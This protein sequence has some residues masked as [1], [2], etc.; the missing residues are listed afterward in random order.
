M[1]IVVKVIGKV[2]KILFGERVVLNCIIRVSGVVMKVRNLVKFKEEWNWNGEI[3]GICKIMF[4]FCMVEKYVFFVGGVLMYWYDLL[5]M[6][7][8]KDNYIW[9]VGSVKCVVGDVRKVGGFFIKIEVECCSIDEVRE[10][11]IVGV[12]VVMFDNFELDVFYKI[13]VVLK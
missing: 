10:V 1:I 9:I 13:V 5:L 4:G 7:M 6:I 12:N 3:V 8:F 11:V 2:N